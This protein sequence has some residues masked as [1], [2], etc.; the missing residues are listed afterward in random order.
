MGKIQEEGLHGD[1]RTDGQ[2]HAGLLQGHSGKA[3]TVMLLPLLSLS[4]APDRQTDH[5]NSDAPRQDHPLDISIAGVEIPDQRIPPGPG[6]PF[7]LSQD[8]ADHMVDGKS[9]DPGHDAGK[10]RPEE[11]VHPQIPAYQEQ[12]PEEASVKEGD[13]RHNAPV[14]G[15]AGIKTDTKHHEGK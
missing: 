15:T 12:K 11:A 10:T 7:S 9:I 4:V 1:R 2:R 5:S 3:F 6:M 14:G 8:Q 13:G